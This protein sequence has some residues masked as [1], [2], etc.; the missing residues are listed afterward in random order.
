MKLPTIKPYGDYSGG[1]YAAHIAA[2]TT[3][4]RIDKGITD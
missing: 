2:Y 4:E 3:L 1:N